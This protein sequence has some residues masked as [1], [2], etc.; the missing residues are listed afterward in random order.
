MPCYD[1]S[2][3]IYD[4]GLDRGRAGDK[5]QGLPIF[6]RTDVRV[7]SDSTKLRV[8]KKSPLNTPIADIGTD[9]VFSRLGP[10]TDLKG[11]LLYEA[12]DI[13]TATRA[14]SATSKGFS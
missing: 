11:A 2:T 4:Q 6:S 12:T 10:T 9:I 14:I 1:V 3:T 8:S 7:G 13:W 5:P